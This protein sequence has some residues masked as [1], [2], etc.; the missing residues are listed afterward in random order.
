MRLPMKH[1]YSKTV[2]FILVLSSAT[3]LTGSAYAETASKESIRALM[4]KTGAG[5]MGVQMMDQLLPAL[6]QML[7]NA[8]DDFWKDVMAELSGDEIIEMVI[9][10]YQ[11]YLTASDIKEINAFYETEAGKKMI[12]VQPDIMRESMALGQQWGQDVARN[13]LAKY[14]QRAKAQQQP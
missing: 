8:P 1:A 3:F 12:R 2:F 4:K 13:V 6:K 11:K 14:K 9:P 5:D 7:P 10:V